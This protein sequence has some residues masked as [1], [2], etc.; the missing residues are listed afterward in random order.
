MVGS[1]I[2]H[3]R[4][5]REHADPC[6]AAT[7]GQSASNGTWPALASRSPTGAERVLL[8]PDHASARGG[9]SV[10]PGPTLQVLGLGVESEH[11]AE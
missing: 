11:S 4:N 3:R 1:A 8:V 6:S 7:I 10:D 9:C 2:L 5:G